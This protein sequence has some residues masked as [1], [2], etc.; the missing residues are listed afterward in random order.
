MTREQAIDELKFLK[1]TLLRK[2]EIEALDMAISALS[3]K[4]R[5]MVELIIEECREIQRNNNDD[6]EPYE[7][8]KWSASDE[9]KDY[10]ESLLKQ[11]EEK[12]DE[13]IQ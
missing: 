11:F 4:Q 13:H 10:A 2:E 7:C 1:K 9:I 6:Y 12:E 5:E 8:G 3:E